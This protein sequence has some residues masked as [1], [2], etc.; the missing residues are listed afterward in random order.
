MLNVAIQMRNLHVLSVRV[1]LRRE[2]HVSQRM[3]FV[4]ECVFHKHCLFVHTFSFY[5]LL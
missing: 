2:T 5:P 1:A 3:V 4:F